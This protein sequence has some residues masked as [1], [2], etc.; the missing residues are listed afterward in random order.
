MAVRRAAHDGERLTTHALGSCVGVVLYD[1]IA[2]IGGLLHAMLPT[3]TQD[4]TRAAT[5]PALFVDTGIP[6]L[7]HAAYAAGARKE[8]LWV[9]LVGGAGRPEDTDLFQVGR[10]NVAMA[11]RLFWHNHV[12]L[13]DEETGGT[14]TWRTVHLTLASGQLHLRTPEGTRVLQPGDRVVSFPPAAVSA[15]RHPRAPGH[16]PEASTRPAMSVP[17][18]WWARRARHPAASPAAPMGPRLPPSESHMD[19]PSAV[20]PANRLHVLVVDDSRVMRQVVRK[21]L[22]MTG[23]PL[24]MIHQMR[25]KPLA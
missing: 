5:T 1:P 9:Y 7:F 19:I 4:A 18:A 8:R 20:E 6:T 3:S 2:R 12:V 23:L 22:G 24:G 16:L 17:P 10:R 21:V 11:R 13:A 14:E 15:P 25:G